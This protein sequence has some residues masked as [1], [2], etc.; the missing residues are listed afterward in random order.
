MIDP[1][2]IALLQGAGLEPRGAAVY[3]HLIDHPSSAVAD[4]ARGTAIGVPQVRAAL[5]RLESGGLVSRSIGHPPRYAPASPEVAVEVLVL[6]R[7]EELERTRLLAKNLERRLRTALHSTPVDLIEV[8]AG[9]QAAAER[10]AQLQRA[11]HREVLIFDKPP[12]WTEGAN[13]T[14]F[15]LLERGVRYRT[16]YARDALATSERLRTVER[17]VRAGEK[18]RVFATL[19][20]K[21]SVYDGNR[22]LA[23][24]R[25]DR[26]GT[27]GALLVHSSP[28]LEA[29]LMLFETIWERAVSFP[30]HAAA[31]PEASSPINERDRQLLV[32]LAAGLKDV[33]I[34]REMKIG[35]RTVERSIKKLMKLLGAETRFQLGLQAAKKEYL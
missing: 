13:E 35:V 31:P 1:S 21:L 29:L 17:Y 8:V 28:L 6:R 25:L 23:P 5:A 10:F 3:V 24:L 14:E 16:I 12:Y 9:R 4:I 19:P 34:A 22:A 26:P 20:M 11:A 32:F 15:E 30:D 33:A 18:A 2:Y 27:E 7:Q